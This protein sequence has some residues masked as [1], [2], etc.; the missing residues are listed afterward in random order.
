M[1]LA[2]FDLDHTL[3]PFDSG[4]AFTRFLVERGDLPDHVEEGY[5]DW[6]RRY[7][8]GGFDIIEVHRFL[9]GA[10]G[11]LEPP[12]LDDAMQAFEATLEKRVPMRTRALVHEHKKV[13]HLCALVTATARFIA[14]PFARVLGIDH[15]MASEPALDAQ[16]RYTGELVGP[17]CFREHKR[18]HVEQWLA[19]RGL[20]GRRSSEL[21]LFRLVAR[22]LV[23][24]GGQRPRGG[25]PGPAT[26][27]D[28]G[29]ARLARAAAG[30]Q[31]SVAVAQAQ[32][33]TAWRARG[34]RTA[35]RARPRCIGPGHR[36]PSRRARRRSR[37]R[38]RTRC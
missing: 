27:G 25:R 17:A 1:K 15:L 21:V 18:T 37:S 7:T 33:D 4:R 3:I 2:L 19:G 28:R 30:R 8:T 23:A 16:G 26:R 22:P 32:S 10:I 5:L 35:R 9:V 36:T 24:G 38:G 20:A 12:L 14:E 11:R 29:R 31:A 34:R 13:G 6:T